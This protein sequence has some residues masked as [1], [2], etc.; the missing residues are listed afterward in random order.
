LLK[1]VISSILL[2]A[3]GLRAG[4]LLGLN[5]SHFDGSAVAVEQTVWDGKVGTPKTMNSYRTVDLHP[6]VAALLKRFIG[7][8]TTGFIFQT[9]GGKPITQ[10]NLLRR[11]FHPLL[12]GLGI[13]KRGFHCFRRFR[14]TYLRKSN[15]P[16]GLLK[17]WMGHAGR[18]MSD[19]YDRVR[20][21]LKFRR[22]VSL[23]MG[24]G[25]DIPNALNPKAPKGRK[26]PPKV[27]VSGVIGRQ[28][29]TQIS[30]NR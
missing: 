16:D 3:S 24:V 5:V 14:N 7:E 25:F 13:S 29:E 1:A 4:E 23:L 19:T 6:N 11:E 28:Q 21:D 18:S 8:R 26:S 30:V 12:E 15:C 10:T 9:R 20:E 22:D 27:L 17:F 2:A